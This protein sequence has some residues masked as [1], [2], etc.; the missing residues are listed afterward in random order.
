MGSFSKLQ[1]ETY[2]HTI[3]VWI[4]ENQPKFRNLLCGFFLFVL[5]SLCLNKPI[6][7]FSYGW[8]GSA[9]KLSR[10]QLIPIVSLQLILFFVSFSFSPF[11]TLS[12]LPL[13]FVRCVNIIFRI[14]ESKKKQKRSP[15][16]PDCIR[17]NKWHT[18]SYKQ[19]TTNNCDCSFAHFSL[20]HCK[21]FHIIR[22]LW[23]KYTHRKR[24]RWRERERE[25]FAQNKNLSCSNRIKPNEI[26]NGRKRGECLKH[27]NSRIVFGT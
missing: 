18:T 23:H 1:N 13:N 20:F 3:L 4:T 27:R 21:Q 19:A 5:F 16:S 24:K 17:H 22:F 2:T 10:C 7:N 25:K 9:L 12:L 8:I 6:S 15:V 11:T 26:E 14:F